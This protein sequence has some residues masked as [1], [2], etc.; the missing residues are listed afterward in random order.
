MTA[1]PQPPK[2]GAGARSSERDLLI[3]TEQI[4]E[5]GPKLLVAAQ[6]QRGSDDQLYELVCDE[7]SIKEEHE[8]KRLFYVAVTRAKN[9]L[10]LLGNA[11]A[12]KDRTGPGS[13][14]RT[15]RSHCAHSCRRAGKGCGRG[16]R[17]REI[18]L[19]EGS[20]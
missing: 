16:F 3:W 2:L 17:R 19:R 15:W 7:L 9:R 1:N 11:D 6:P 20:A 4:N 18:S 5:D 14:R 10:Y 13:W 12:R 8:L